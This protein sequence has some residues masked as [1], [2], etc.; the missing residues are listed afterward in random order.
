M[1]AGISCDEHHLIPRAKGG[2]K[3]PTIQL[4]RICHEK[5]HSLWTEGQ[6]AKYFNTVERIVEFPEMQSFISWVRKRPIDF[7]MPTKQNTKKRR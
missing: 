5:I 6:L 2:L 7:Y 4:H 1:I 3:G